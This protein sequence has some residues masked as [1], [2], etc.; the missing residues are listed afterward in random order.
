MIYLI[1][2]QKHEDDGISCFMALCD[3]ERAFKVI[4]EFWPTFNSDEY[5][6][7]IE[8]KGE[9]GNENNNFNIRNYTYNYIGSVN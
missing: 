9:N 1:R 4:T 7:I 8:L 6:I 5:R 3:K 2:I